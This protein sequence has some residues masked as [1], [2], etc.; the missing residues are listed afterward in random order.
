MEMN[1]NASNMKILLDEPENV[2]WKVWSRTNFIQHHPTWF[3]SS[4]F[5]FIKILKSLKC[6]QRFIQHRK[7][8]ILDAMLDAFAA[9]FSSSGNQ[10]F[11]ISLLV[12]D[13]VLNHRLSLDPAKSLINFFSILCF[14]YFA[15]N[16]IC[17]LNTAWYLWKPC[18]LSRFIYIPI[19]P[20]II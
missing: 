10:K 7:F 11:C 15:S 1:S 14:L 6:I 5:F 19:F 3:F 8:S 13:E 4:F 20:F 18:F 9:A 17:M 16:R 12:S 2:G